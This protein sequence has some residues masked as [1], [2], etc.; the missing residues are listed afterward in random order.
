VVRFQII[1]DKNDHERQPFT[2]HFSPFTKRPMKKIHERKL[3]ALA[4]HCLDGQTLDVGCSARPNPFIPNV[5]GLDV[6]PTSALTENYSGFHLCNLNTDRMPL[7]DG[8]FQN[9]VAGDLI[10][11]LENPS[12]FLC[13]ANRVLASGGRLILCTPQANDWWVT[14]HNWFFRRWITDPDPGEH[15]QNWTILDM[16][17]LLKKN[18]FRVRAV[19]GLHFQT[20]FVPIRFRVRRFPALAWQVIYVA[21]KHASPNMDILVGGGNDYRFV[22]Q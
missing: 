21:E 1:R 6:I 4:G 19:E 18:G 3:R 7:A 9:L 20:P 5:V 10:E 22:S 14:L 12:Q 13:D 17:R 16:T 11:H 8:S 15:L 2:V